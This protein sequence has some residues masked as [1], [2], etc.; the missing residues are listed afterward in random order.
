MAKKTRNST[1]RTM[2]PKSKPIGKAAYEAFYVSFGNQFKVPAKAIK[3][4]I[5]PWEEIAPV[6]QTAWVKAAKAAIKAGK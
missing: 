4:S 5:M 2:K 3:K 6:H 1:N